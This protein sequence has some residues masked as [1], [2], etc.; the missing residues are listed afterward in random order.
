M[1]TI[2][3]NCYSRVSP[4]KRGH[5][6]EASELILFAA[7]SVPMGRQRGT[8]AGDASGIPSGSLAPLSHLAHLLIGPATW[9]ATW[10]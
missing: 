4:P 7:Q 2:R 10:A 5:A 8:A 9:A 6:G 1:C 3:K